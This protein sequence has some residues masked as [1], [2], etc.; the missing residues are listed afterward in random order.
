MIISLICFSLIPLIHQLE[1]TYTVTTQQ[2]ALK[3][4]LYHI[5]KVEIPNERQDFLKYEVYSSH[6]K[7]CIQDTQSGQKYCHSK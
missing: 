4:T 1:K 7:I 6:H 3:R 5:I 2:L